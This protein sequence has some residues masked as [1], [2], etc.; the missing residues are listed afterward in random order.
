MGK[1][2]VAIKAKAKFLE[3]RRILLVAKN[4]KTKVKKFRKVELNK[5]RAVKASRKARKYLRMVLKGKNKT[6]IR[7]AKLAVKKARKAVKKLVRYQRSLSR[8]TSSHYTK[9][10][11]RLV[12]RFISR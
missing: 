6:L 9:K 8:R 2:V 10:E 7:V 4:L 5:K 11:R 3:L 1:K 12:L